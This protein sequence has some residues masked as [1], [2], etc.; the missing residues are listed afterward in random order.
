MHSRDTRP[1]VS[2]APF[3]IPDKIPSISRQIGE[4][5]GKRQLKAVLGDIP[6]DALG[7]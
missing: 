1:T 6:T 4:M 5:G 3:L 2:V 7:S